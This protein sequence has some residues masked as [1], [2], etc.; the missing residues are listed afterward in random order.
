[1]L[2][3]LRY[4]SDDLERVFT[5]F[6]GKI[7]CA[8]AAIRRKIPYKNRDDIVRD[9][10]NSIDAAATSFTFIYIILSMPDLEI[11]DPVKSRL[12]D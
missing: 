6:P 4:C 1:M 2:R 12:V 8:G 3:E 5:Y 9:F 11:F 7:V 10:E